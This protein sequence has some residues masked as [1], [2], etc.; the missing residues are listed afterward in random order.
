M[1]EP[2]HGTSHRVTEHRN[3]HTW[4]GYSVRTINIDENEEDEE[5]SE[6]KIK[7]THTRL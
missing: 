3:K 1:L 2:G 7:S 5:R 4:G 6:L